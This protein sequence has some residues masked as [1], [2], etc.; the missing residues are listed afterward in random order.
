MKDGVMKLFDKEIPPKPLSTAPLKI[1][2]EKGDGQKH[3]V[4]D[5]SGK[6]TSATTIVADMSTK[7]DIV[8]GKAT[9]AKK[10]K[11]IEESKNPV[12]DENEP[13]AGWFSKL[14]L[15]IS[16]QSDS[17]LIV[18]SI[19]FIACL[20]ALVLLLIRLKNKNG[21]STEEREKVLTQLKEWLD[22]DSTS[23]VQELKA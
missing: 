2:T 1:P 9:Q 6:A 11:F 18:F 8:A 13:R 15:F 12:S 10:E 17:D 7:K 22:R 20:L 19:I 16:G 4:T 5:N 23:M 14:K 3:I 21:L